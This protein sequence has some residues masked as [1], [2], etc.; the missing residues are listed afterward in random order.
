[1][2]F[3]DRDLLEIVEK[4]IDNNKRKNDSNAHYWYPLNYATYGAEEITSALQSMLAFKTSMADKCKLYENLFSKFIDSENSIFVNSGSSADLLAISALVKSPEYPLNKGD[5]VLVPSITWPTQIWSIIQAGLEP[6]LFDCD[7]DT[8]N[9]NIKSVPNNILKECKCI[10]TTHI[11]GTCANIDDIQ[12]I[13]DSYNLIFLEDACESL[14]CKYKKKQVGTFGA[15]GTFSSFFSH[16]ITTMEG[17]IVCTNNKDLE[18][19]IRIMRAHGWSRAIQDGGLEIFCNK[20]NIDLSKYESIDTRYLFVDEGYNLRPTEINASFGI[21]QI[22][23]IEQFNL[24][25]KFLAE[26][27]Y[28]NLSNL[29][30]LKGPIVDKDCEPCFMSLPIK[31]IN[32]EYTNA[33]AIKFL[34]ERGVESRPLIAG[35]I[36]NHPV[37][38]I[39]NFS[40]TQENL[41]GANYHHKNSF[42]VGLSS[43]HTSEDIDRL[44]LV[45]KDLDKVLNT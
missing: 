3:L 37:S 19:Q 32:S 28:K 26:K 30:N 10:F 40:S 34:E 43:K 11:L 15:L 7:V 1:M 31:I 23:K 33:K 29:N 8:F 35:N 14:G 24:H 25:R 5:K 17:G 20:R 36:L 38:K 45:M 27:F 44:S 6:V 13:C 41:N 39:F 18:L 16:H 42:Y 12:D 2:E 4:K 9:P 21:Y 22:Q